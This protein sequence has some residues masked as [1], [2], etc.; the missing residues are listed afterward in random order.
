MSCISAKVRYSW[1]WSV[2]FC[3]N[4]GILKF[5]DA[6]FVCA[7]SPQI[8]SWMPSHC[9]HSNSN[10]HSSKDDSWRSSETRCY[11]HI[12]LCE[13]AKHLHGSA[14]PP[15]FQGYRYV[16]TLI[17]MIYWASCISYLSLLPSRSEYLIYW[18]TWPIVQ[19]NHMYTY[20]I[21]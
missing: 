11:Y 17:W 19:T 5:Q 14:K 7:E 4:W 18:A 12:R 10:P 1:S 2:K 8:F 6:V 3:C 15:N 13:Q 9:A 20:V 21:S 16:R